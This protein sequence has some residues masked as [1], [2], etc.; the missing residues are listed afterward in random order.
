MQGE[1]K[2]PKYHHG[3]RGMPHYW[4]N[5][6]IHAECDVCGAVLPLSEFHRQRG[7][8]YGHHLAC[9]DCFNYRV[10]LASPEN[11][12]P[13]RPHSLAPVIAANVVLYAARVEAGLPIF[14]C[15]QPTPDAGT[16]PA[17]AAE[18]SSQAAT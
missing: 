6:E 18:S 1:V 5:G 7:C 11:A 17:S 10:W 2:K 3:Q 12:D 8:R 14:N 9:R 4:R 13:A 15:P 16:C